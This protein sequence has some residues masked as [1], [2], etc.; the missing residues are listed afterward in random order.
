MSGRELTGCPWGAGASS[1]TPPVLPGTPVP[2]Q[3]CPAMAPVPAVKHGCPR[4]EARNQGAVRGCSTASGDGRLWAFGAALGTQGS[5]GHSGQPWPFRATVVLG[6]CEPGWPDC[7]PWC[8][9]AGDAGGRRKRCGLCWCG[10]F[11]A[12][13]SCGW[14]P[15]LGAT[16]S[17]C[18]LVPGALW[19][20]VPSPV[21]PGA[22][23]CHLWSLLAVLVCASTAHGT[24]P[25]FH[26]SS[27]PSALSS[28]H[29]MSM[30][31]Y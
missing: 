13:R 14:G 25:L 4:G 9:G 30:T 23:T 27:N 12:G 6:R 17:S 3:G 21:P 19:R 8:G 15:C 16:S 18:S 10:V 29:F 22:L 26:D 1:P 20:G 7:L 5:C 2:Q 11:C 24:F 28:N 31:N